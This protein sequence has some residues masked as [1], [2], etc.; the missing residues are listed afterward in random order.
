MRKRWIL[1]AAAAAVA[2]GG[3]QLFEANKYRLPGLVQRL[4]DP[5]QPNQPVAWSKGPDTPAA[6]P[7]AR[8]PNIILIVV[9]DLGINDISAFGGGHVPTPA[10]DALMKEGASVDR[11]YTA[12]ATCSPSRAAMMTGRYPTRFGFEFTAVPKSF[13]QNI[14]HTEE[15]G[16]LRP[17]YFADRAKDVPP[18]EDM[19]MP[20]SEVT[21]AEVLKQAGYQTLHIGKWHLGVARGMRPEDQGFDE[22]LGIMGGAGLFLPKDSAEVENAY[23]PWDPID[24]FIWANLPYAVQWNGGRHFAPRGYVTDYFTDEAIA[25][26]EANRNRPFFLY[27]AHTAPHT[28]LQALKRDYDKLDHIKDHNR[29]V[30]A[31]MI[32][33]LDRSVARIRAKLAAEGLDRN[34]LILFTSDNGGAWYVGM[35]DLNTPY[36]GWKATFFE[37]GVRAPMFL[38]WPARIA[39]GTR[40]AS[41]AGHWDLLATIAGAAGPQAVAAIPTDRVIDSRSIL[42]GAIDTPR[43]LFWK[44]GHYRAVLDGGWKLQTSERPERSWL[45]NLAE[46]PTE[47]TDLSAIRP[48]KVAEL[49]ARLDTHDAGMPRPLWPALLE[50]PVRIDV[51]SNA[52]W[53]DGQQYVYWAN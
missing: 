2:V 37:G 15:I 25:A 11:F 43:P 52:P 27:L 20:A 34:T 6:P 5:V 45:F 51:P 32:V 13:A 4:T 40:M 18:Y 9:D 41:P 22:S 21:V 33:A 17:I 14:A 19:G 53:K 42:D 7:E 49:K 30:Y 38:T 16:P 12:N 26:I 28:P 47:Q 39:P 29:R 35:D 3:W 31:A 50:G 8:P 36:R 1:L 24:R 44:S 10:I 46:D 23:L 48:D